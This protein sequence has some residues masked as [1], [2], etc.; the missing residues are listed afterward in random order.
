MSDLSLANVRRTKQL[1]LQ[2]IFN[3]IRICQINDILT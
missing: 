1:H 2:V 3:Y